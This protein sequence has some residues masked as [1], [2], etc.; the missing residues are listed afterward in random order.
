MFFQI[1]DKVLY[2]M[3]GAGIIEAIEE[4]EILGEYRQYYIISIPISNM[5][6]MIPINSVEKAGVRLVT[7]SKTMKSIIFDFHNEEPTCSLP[8]KERYKQNIEKLKTGDTLDGAEVIR[9]LLHLQKEKPLNSSEKQ[10]LNDASKILI[11]ELSIIKD[12]SE[13]QAADLLVI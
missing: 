2:P 12:I 7:D 5:N 1:G 11:S 4:K 6:V 3:H 10:M 13:T 8:W 9:D